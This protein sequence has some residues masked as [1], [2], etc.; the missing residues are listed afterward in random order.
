MV[1]RGFFIQNLWRRS[2]GLDEMP[3]PEMVDMN[4]L[5]MSEWSAEFEQLMRNRLIIGALRYGKL[6]SPGKPQYDRTAA[7]KKRIQQ[8]IDTGNKELLVDCANLC[9][10][11]FE[12][13][14]HPK[15]HFHAVDDGTHVD[16]T[17]GGKNAKRKK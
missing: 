6:N 13:C 5:A 8:Y 11:E 4:S 1:D 2:A 3:A 10:L 17:I 14:F 16:I 9:M 15:A 12:E 7:I